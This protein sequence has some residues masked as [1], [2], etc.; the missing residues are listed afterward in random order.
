MPNLLGLGPQYKTYTAIRAQTGKW[1]RLAAEPSAEQGKNSFA[2]L[3]PLLLVVGFLFLGNNSFSLFAFC[4]FS[5]AI[6]SFPLCLSTPSLGFYLPFCEFCCFN[7]PRLVWNSK[8]LSSSDTR[9][10][11]RSVA[12]RSIHVILIPRERSGAMPILQMC[13]QRHR[14]VTC[15]RLHGGTAR[16]WA[17]AVQLQSTCSYSPSILF[18]MYI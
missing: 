4:V 14:E 9:V 11:V 6:E 18:L 8:Y 7:T 13:L 1:K 17:P 2:L 16:I 10:S 15:P 3:G 12:H 5:L